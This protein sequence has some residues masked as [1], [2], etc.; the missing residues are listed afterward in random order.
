VTDTTESAPK[1]P[2]VYVVEDDESSRRATERLLKAA[3]HR[4]RVYA[5]PAEF[6]GEV[7]DGPGC[8]VL[9]LR[10]PGVSG[11]DLQTLL[12]T[13][14][15]PLPVVFVTGHGD[16]PKSVRAMKAG[17]VDFLTKPVDPPVLLAAVAHAL[18]RDVEQRATRDRRQDARGRYERLTP[19][20]RE[21]FAHVISGQLNKQVAY[22]LG[23]TEHTIKVHRQRVMQ[24]LGVDSV[25]ELVRLAS[26]LG[27]TPIGSTRE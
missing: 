5:S 1:T 24:K 27:I 4:V 3:G 23:T 7:P 9:D 12:T 15:N 18:S 19:R 25:A 20:E 6:L 10:L 14:E 17:A 2:V 8:L 11:L 22:D 21:V 13:M 16:V 26:D